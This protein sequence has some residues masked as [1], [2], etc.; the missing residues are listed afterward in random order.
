MKL[1]EKTL[2]LKLASWQIRMTQDFLDVKKPFREVSINFGVIKCPASYKI[3]FEG[4]SRSDWVL[5]LTDDQMKTVQ[6]KFDLK[7]PI[8]GINITE[9]LIEKDQVIFQ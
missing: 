2:R 6:E 7:S 1:Q 5:Y 9:G 3:P 8:S 4:L